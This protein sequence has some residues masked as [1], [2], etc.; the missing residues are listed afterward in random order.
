MVVVWMPGIVEAVIL[1]RERRDIRNQ[2]L[3]GAA[4]RRHHCEIHR[5]GLAGDNLLLEYRQVADPAAGRRNA[6]HTWSG[7]AVRWNQQRHSSASGIHRGDRRQILPEKVR[8]QGRGRRGVAGSTGGFTSAPEHY[9][10]G[11]VGI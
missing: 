5:T 2:D 11:G 6:N 9:H 8:D 1:G 4:I 10:C 7:R 3:N